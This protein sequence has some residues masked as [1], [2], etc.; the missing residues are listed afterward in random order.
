MSTEKHT[1][2]HKTQNHMNKGRNTHAPY[3][4]F[5]ALNHWTILLRVWRNGSMVGRRIR[6][7]KVAGSTPGLCAT[8]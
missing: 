3:M 7:R 1:N 5:T 4:T 2:T 6:D 8:T